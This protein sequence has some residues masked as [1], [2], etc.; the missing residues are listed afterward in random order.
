MFFF[1]LE[2]TLILFP[3]FRSLPQT[4]GLLAELYMDPNSPW[5]HDN[6]SKLEQICVGNLE[7]NFAATK[8]TK[9]DLPV[10]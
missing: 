9:P 1:P 2:S 3:L 10:L 4:L 8:G 5:W 6:V 7:K